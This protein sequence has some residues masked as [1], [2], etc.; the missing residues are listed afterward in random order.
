MAYE[1]IT[2]Y[3]QRCIAK[4]PAGKLSE[5]TVSRF[6]QSR[7]H[8]THIGGMDGD[9]TALHDLLSYYMTVA[10]MFCDSRRIILM[11]AVG[12]S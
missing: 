6:T 2:G 10:Y 7:F 9:Q 3:L 8:N 12:L 11:S 4:Q 1:N 5:D